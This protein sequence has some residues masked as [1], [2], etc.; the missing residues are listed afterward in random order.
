MRA[1]RYASL[2]K[3]RPVVVLTRSR[4]V[5]R[6]S[7]VAVAAITSTIRGLA[8]EVRV[9]ESNGLHHAC[10]INMDNVYTIPHASLGRQL[11]WL[12]PEQEA[13]L[14]AALVRAFDLA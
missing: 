1:I 10:V 11:G 3:L 9:D 14:H 5:G 7:T 12:H 4:A 13:A 6:L 2:D 8:T